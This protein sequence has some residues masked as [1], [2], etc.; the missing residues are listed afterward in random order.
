MIA[1]DGIKMNDNSVDVVGASGQ[2]SVE[3][4]PVSY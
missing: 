4:M 3:M 2:L 1:Q